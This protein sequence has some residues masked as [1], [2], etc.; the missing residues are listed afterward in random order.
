MKEITWLFDLSLFWQLFCRS[1][2]TVTFYLEGSWLN[3]KKKKIK[4]WKEQE[5]ELHHYNIENY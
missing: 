2:K 1:A 5:Q 3:T 4:T